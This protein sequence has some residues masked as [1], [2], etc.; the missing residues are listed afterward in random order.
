MN[1]SVKEVKEEIK[2]G[3][4]AYIQK[5]EQGEYCLK[6]VNRIP[7]YLEGKPG[8]GKTEIVRQVASELGIGFVNFSITHHTRNSL[9]GLPVISELECGKYTEY[10]MSEIIA[11][12]VEKEEAGQKEGILLLDEFNCAS[13]TIMPTMLAFLQTRNIGKYRLPEGWSIVLCGN[14]TTY[15]KSARVFDAAILDRV[16]KME[17]EYNIKD[18]L[19]YAKKNK[20]HA[21]ILEFLEVNKHYFYRCGDGKT[22]TEIVTSRGW[23]NLSHTL[24]MYEKLDQSI[25]DK[26]IYQYL[27]SVEVA[28]AFSD[29]YWMFMGKISVNEL[30]DITNNKNTEKYR[31][32]A[33]IENFQ[34][35]W[36]LVEQLS[37]TLITDVSEQMERIEERGQ[38]V[39]LYADVSKKIENTISF[40]ERLDDAQSLLESL[41]RQLNKSKILVHILSNIRNEKY[42]NLCRKA[43]GEM[44][45]FD[46]VHAII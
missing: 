12:V 4:R 37:N 17:V 42:L 9:L 29:F 14:P 34:F 21:S 28:H 8:I 31:A 44:Q 30:R 2:K 13:E 6:S 36:K 26:L 24:K 3:I 33:Q 46:E 22:D 39:L 35:R 18:F 10:T 16:R 11:A 40:L 38:N 23:E 20:F 1:Y 25:D 32:L 45:T 15:N 7:F 5:D 43:F 27:K 19:E 41:L